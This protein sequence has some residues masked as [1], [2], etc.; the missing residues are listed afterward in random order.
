LEFNNAALRYYVDP[1][2]RANLQYGYDRW[3]RRPEERGRID[4]LLQAVSRI[5]EKMDSRGIDGNAWLRDIG[6]VSWRG[7]MTKIL[8]APYEERDEW[9]LNIMVHGS[10]L[11]LEEHLSSDRI[12]EK[13]EISPHHRK[14]MY[15]GYAF[16]SYCTSPHPQPVRA[17]DVQEHP[18]GWGGDVDT[19][20]QWCSVVKTKLDNIRI[21]I[22]GEVDCVRGEFTGKTDTYVELKT[23]MTIRNAQD[24][25]RFE[26]KLLKFYFQSFLLGVPEIV[27]GFRTPSGQLSTVQKFKTMEIPRLVRDKPGAWDPLIC[28][29]WGKRFFNFLQSTVTSDTEK[30]SINVWRAKFTPR[31]GVTLSLLGDAEVAEVVNGEERIGFLPKWYV[32][33]LKSKA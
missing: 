15:Y 30:G 18:R 28:L 3:I 32:D 22:G 11:Y 29:D 14:Q 1:P 10:T 6:V 16:E 33:S 21:V 23:S 5:K 9:E 13:N 12:K 7:V 31:E 25:A 19:N 4:S 24:E 20:V 2:P 26:K 8:T 17:Q 27:V